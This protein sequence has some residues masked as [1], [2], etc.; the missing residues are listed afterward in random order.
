MYTHDVCPQEMIAVQM[1]RKQLYIEDRQQRKLH[2][3]ATQW[4][5]SEA[6]VM[7]AALDRLPDPD[8]SVLD[9]L[10]AAGVLLPPPEESDLP[11]GKEAAELEAELEAWLETQM[12]PLGLSQAVMEDRR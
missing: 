1:I 8:A 9:R 12:E 4:G 5:C 11:S 10:E 7:R 6:E 3:L 2:R